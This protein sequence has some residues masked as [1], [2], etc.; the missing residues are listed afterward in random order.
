NPLG[1]AITAALLIYTYWEPIKAFFVWLWDGVKAAFAW[2]WEGITAIVSSV[3]DTIMA[4]VD[5]GILG[6][7][8]LIINWSPIGL[9]YQAFAAVLSWFGVDLPDTF[10]GF[11]KMLIDGLIAGVMGAAGFLMEKVKS[12]GESVAGAVKSALGI[13]SP[14]KVFAQIGGYSMAGLEQGLANT[15]DGPLAYVKKFAGTMATAGAL[16]VGPVMSP[17]AHAAAPGMAV[18]AAGAS[19]GVA[20]ATYQIT[21]NAAPGMDEAKLAEL[22]AKKIEEVERNKAARARSRLTDAE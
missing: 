11:G 22:V 2:A 8:A 16:A 1:L 3:W 17:L 20:A 21:I 14:S 12:L 4:A 7:A 15:A 5:G 19:G 9:F 18:G 6:V 10:T 13:S